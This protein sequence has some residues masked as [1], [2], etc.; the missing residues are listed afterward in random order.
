MKISWV[1]RF[2]TFARTRH[3]HADLGKGQFGFTAHLFNRAFHVSEVSAGVARLVLGNGVVYFFNDGLGVPLRGAS[4]PLCE[5]N[6][7][8]EMQH[9]GFERGCRIEGKTYRMQFLLGR[10]QIGTKAMQIIHQHQRVLLLLIE[11]DRHEC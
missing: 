10:H 1:Q 11:P 6:L 4:I 3:Q 9:Q 5:A 8:A 7:A 2:A